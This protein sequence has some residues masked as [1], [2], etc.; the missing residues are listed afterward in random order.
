M[1][2]ESVWCYQSLFECIFVEIFIL[3]LGLI[4]A[5]GV[6]PA[7]KFGYYNC[8]T[9]LVTLNGLFQHI[10]DTHKDVST[11]VFFLHVTVLNI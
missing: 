9:P 11:L 2:F 1:D 7:G 8:D 10:K 6:T 3:I 4:V 5:K